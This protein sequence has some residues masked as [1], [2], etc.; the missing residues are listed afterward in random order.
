MKLLD[1]LLLLV[2]LTGLLW[3]RSPQDAAPAPAKPQLSDL[4]WMGGRWE[5]QI[6]GLLMEE[7]WMAPRG[8]SM[9]GMHRDVHLGRDKTVS[10][11][12]LRI[13]ADD[14]GIRYLASPGGRPPTPFELT[15]V[16]PSEA[17]FANPQHDFPQ[18]ILYFLE[19]DGAVLRA[20]VEGEGSEPMEWRWRRLP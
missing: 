15:S 3:L 10:F 20:R 18:R 13:V 8:G 7:H 11:E 6:D 4:A 9:I 16:S 5:A 19:E 17:V 12:F 1:A 2:P 14:K